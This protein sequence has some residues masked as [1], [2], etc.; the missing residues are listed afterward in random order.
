M[1]GASSAVN[2]SKCKVLLDYSILISEVWPLHAVQTMKIAE[3]IHL[4]IN[5]GEFLVKES[6]ICVGRHELIH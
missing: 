4:S 1:D 3:C 5:F 6:S 2:E